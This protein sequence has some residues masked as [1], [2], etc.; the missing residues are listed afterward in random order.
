MKKMIICFILVVVVI[1]GGCN[2]PQPLKVE[3]TELGFYDKKND[4]QYVMCSEKDVRPLEVGEEYATDGKITYYKIPWEKTERFI[5]DSIEGVSYVYR[6]LTVEDITINNFNPVSAFIYLEGE[7]SLYLDTLYCE[8]KYLPDDKKDENQRDDS[9]IVYSIRDALISGERVNVAFEDMLPDDQYFIRLLS[10]DY[11]GLYYI[12]IFFT[13]INGEAYLRIRGED[14]T[15]LAPD[16]V[17][18]KMIDDD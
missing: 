1:L 16:I 14:I 6:A 9:A 3:P 5:C 8:Q 18:L 11:P 7:R 2:K 12:V 4:I 17:E 13:D 15:V 10:P